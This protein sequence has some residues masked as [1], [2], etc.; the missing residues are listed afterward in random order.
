MYAGSRAIESLCLTIDLNKLQVQ[1][2]T[3][4]VL[5]MAPI[6]DKWTS[7]GWAVRSVDGND[8]SD[9]DAGYDWL[10]TQ[11]KPGVLIANTLVG[12]GVPFLEGK[13]SHNMVLPAAVANDALEYLEKTL[14]DPTQGAAL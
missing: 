14:I 1:G 9:L 11:R 4:T 10:R 7:F 2:D 3:S 8:F 5:T 13:M 6:A 12:K